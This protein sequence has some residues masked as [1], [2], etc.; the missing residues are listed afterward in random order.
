[1]FHL[2]VGGGRFGGF[3]GRTLVGRLLW[4]LDVVFGRF[5]QFCWFGWV[6]FGG[7]KCLRRR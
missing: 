3:C 7:Q 4:W 5:A 6:L 2:V 1:M